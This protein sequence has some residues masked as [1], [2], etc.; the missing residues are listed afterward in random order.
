MTD[1]LDARGPVMLGVE[2]LV[3]TDADRARLRD[4]R[5]GGVVLFTRNFESSAQLRALTE[6][7]R[8]CAAARC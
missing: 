3:L 1:E 4:P 7:I 5:V 2:A 6:S 8:R